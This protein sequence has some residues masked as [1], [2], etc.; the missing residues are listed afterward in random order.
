MSDSHAGSFGER[1]R[2]ETEASSE[3]PSGT[4]PAGGEAPDIERLSRE[5]DE[6]LALWQRAQADYQNQRRRAAGELESQVRAALEPLLEDLLL[7]TDHI[8]MALQSPATTPEAKNLATGVELVRQQLRALLDRAGVSPIPTEGLFDASRHQAVQSEPR[9]DLPA[10]TCV[11]AI[12][13]G[14]LW[15]GRP[16]RFAQVRV[17]TQPN[18]SGAQSQQQP[19]GPAESASAGNAGSKNSAG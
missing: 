17:S 18:D 3:T 10:G 4:T 8:D 15:R 1:E 13:R 14:Y 19:A 16:L 12:R 7:V 6:Y 9:A 5:R 11:A 2:P